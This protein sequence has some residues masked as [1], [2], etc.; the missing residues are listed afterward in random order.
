MLTAVRDP[1]PW[2]PADALVAAVRV[3]PFIERAH[4]RPGDDH[5]SGTIAVALIHPGA[6]HAAAC[7]H[8]R[9][10]G[11]TDRSWLRCETTTVLGTRQLACTMLTHAAANLPL[12]D[13]IGM[14]PAH[15]GVH[16]EARHADGTG[17]TLL[18]LGPYF[19]TWVASQEADRL[20]TELAGRAAAIVMP[21]FTVTVKDALFDVNGHESYSAPYVAHVAAL[22]VRVQVRVRPDEDTPA[23]SPSPCPG[24]RG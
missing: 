11:Y 22:L 6:G 10:L 21:G 13:D 4:P 23:A 3:G 8:G 18:R 17:C 19:Q 9:R 7:L 15:Y 12:P 20:T 2:A 5:D 16:A 14:T 1:Q 24:D